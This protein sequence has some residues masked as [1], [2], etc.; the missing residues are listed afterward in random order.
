M[1]KHAAYAELMDDRRAG[2]LLHPTSLPSGVLGHDAYRFVDFLRASGLRLWQVLP[3]GPTHQDRS[4]YQ[5]LSVHAGNP[6]LIDVEGLREQGWLG[7]Q[8]GDVS[9]PGVRQALLRQACANFHAHASQDARR[10]YEHFVAR[11]AGWLED[12]ALFQ[13]LKQHYP[14]GW[15]Q[16]PQAL[17][18]RDPEAL[19]Q[20]REQF[21]TDYQQALFEQFVF[22]RQWQAL[23]TYANERGVALLGDVPIFVAHD[24]ADVWT[25]RE[26]FLLDEQGRATVV[27]GVPPDYFSAT[28]QRWGNPLYDWQRLA[29]DGYR[30]WLTRLETQ[31]ALFDCVRIDHFRGFEAYWEIPA[32][33]ETA[34][35]GRWVKGPGAEFFRA[36]QQRWG[37]RLPLVAEDLGLITAEVEQLRRQFRLP[38]MKILQFAFDG[39]AD[40][41]YLPHHHER[42]AVVYTG[43]HDNDTTLGWFQGLDEAQRERVYAYF[44]RPREDMPWMLIRQAM[45]SVARWAIVPMQDVLALDGRH[46]MNVPGVA[47]GN[48]RWRFD[49]PQCPPGLEARLHQLVAC[50]GRL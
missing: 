28:G 4:P 1:D 5:S 7:E 8:P 31:L 48:W 37:E 47:Q 14:S 11:H 16:W 29:G 39:G 41:P 35:N 27:A 10:E 43:T 36:L 15:W 25:R 44:G 34:V 23:R 49:W 46:R 3:L 18:D 33:E 42:N 40:N 38:G 32:G 24:S 50:Y 12:Y 6:E 13:A 19:R 20:A 9:D 30:W 2:I 45:A 17:R 21:F 22:F 26:Y